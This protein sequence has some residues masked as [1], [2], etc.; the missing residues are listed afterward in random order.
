VEI[1]FLD[2]II[3]AKFDQL[4]PG[5]AAHDGI[6]PLDVWEVVLD[7]VDTSRG[8]IHLR[9]VRLL[10]RAEG[11]DGWQVW[12]KI[13]KILDLQRLPPVWT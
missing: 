11:D 3:T 1:P 13:H 7:E 12:R 10:E 2:T 9:P 5:F 4:Q 8:R 6:K